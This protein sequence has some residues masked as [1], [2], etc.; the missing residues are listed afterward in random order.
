MESKKLA[1]F[2]TCGSAEEAELVARHLLEKRVAACVNIIPGARSL[3]WWQ[4]QL[5]ES[6]EFVLI[7]K[8]RL[9]RWT[10]FEAELKAVHS[11]TTPELIALPIEQGSAEYLGWLDRELDM[12]DRS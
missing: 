7:A 12:I 6:H 3:Y 8:T 11:Y 4:D 1:V 9:D 2:T 10:E 5:E